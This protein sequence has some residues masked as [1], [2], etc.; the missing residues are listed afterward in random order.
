MIRR[1]ITETLSRLECEFPVITI[2]GP[3]QS[4]K[5]TIVRAHFANHEYVSLEKPSN[6]DLAQKDPEAFLSLHSGPVIFDEAQRCPELF[7][8][9]QEIVDKDNTPGKFILTGSQNFL[10]MKTISQSLAGRVGVTYL[11]PLELC[12]LQNSSVLD[13]TKNGAPASV[14]NVPASEALSA[15]ASRASDA[16][17]SKVPASE[18]PAS[19]VLG[20]PASTSENT[21]TSETIENAIFRGFYPRIYDQN[22]TPNDFYLSYLR[23]YLTRDVTDELGVRKTTG[24]RK[25]LTLCATRVGN[26]LE[27]SSL[28]KSVTI[29][30]STIKS[31]LSLLES[32]FVTFYLQPYYKNFGKRLIKSPKLYFIDT[33]LASHLLKIKSGKQILENDNLRGKL[34]EN[35][36]IAEVLKK[37]YNKGLEPN[38]YFWRDTNGRE[39]DLIIENGGKIS[40]A[41]EIKSTSTMNMNAFKNLNSIGDEMELP[42]ERR[43]V[44]YEGKTSVQTKCGRFLTIDELDNLI[45]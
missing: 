7:S 6:L 23:T 30:A 26:L 27:V 19:E 8:Y 16:S 11:L 35:F 28:A 38:I 12:E 15:P 33:G 13:I 22:I 14:F 36:V 42:K 40:Y 21:H 29:N 18:T 10:L 43:I 17:A 41:V 31:W 44:V 3:R 20:A 24:F 25:N 1:K 32:S 2:T 39:I 45:E 37:Y 34:F 4:G 9:L 5:T